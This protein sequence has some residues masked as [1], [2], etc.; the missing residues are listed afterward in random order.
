MKQRRQEALQKAYRLVFRMIN[1]YQ[2]DEVQCDRTSS[3]EFRPACNA[4]V[5]GS[6][7]KSATALGLYPEPHTP[8]LQISFDEMM[9][10]LDQFALEVLCD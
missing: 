4:M 8:Y 10:L 5:L 9:S 6:P 1:R 3:V 2:R 7:I